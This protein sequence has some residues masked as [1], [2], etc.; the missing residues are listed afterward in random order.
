MGT[1][2]KRSNT[3][4]GA[5]MELLEEFSVTWDRENFTY[6]TDYFPIEISPHDLWLED[7]SETEA[8]WHYLID[9]RDSQRFQRGLDQC[10][11]CI[12]YEIVSV[13]KT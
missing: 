6:P 7:I 3:D 9:P 10:I 5:M 1:R 11:S 4:R 13:G 8:I 12:R 2:R